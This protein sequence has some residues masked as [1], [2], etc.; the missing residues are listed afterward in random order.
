[1]QQC[2]QRR[3]IQSPLQKNGKR[4]RAHVRPI[5]ADCRLPIGAAG[6]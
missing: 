5:A 6:R 3:V 4:D 1:M 2:Y